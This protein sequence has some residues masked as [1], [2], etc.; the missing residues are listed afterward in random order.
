MEPILID[1]DHNEKSPPPH[2]KQLAT[3]SI[4]AP[5]LS[6]LLHSS[7]LTMQ[8]VSAFS[9][10]VICISCA[11]F[12]ISGLIFSIMAL[13][14]IRGLNQKVIFRRAIMGLIINLLLIILNIIGFIFLA[15]R[16]IK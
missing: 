11:F 14:Q 5:L 7:F 13:C 3:A 9:A 15:A 16:G 4:V 1:E 12:I 8:H 10:L 6:W 2:A